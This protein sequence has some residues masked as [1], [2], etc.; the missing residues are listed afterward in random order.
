VAGERAASRVTRFTLQARH[1]RPDAPSASVLR[2][3]ERRFRN[4]IRKERAML[5]HVEI[6]VSDLERSV[7]FWTTFMRMLGY[8]EDRW[9]AG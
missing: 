7:A 1:R 2:A 4:S 3:S 8:S 5:H 6:Y 9:S